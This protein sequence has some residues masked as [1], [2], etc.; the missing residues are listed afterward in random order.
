LLG[1][2]SRCITPAACATLSGGEQLPGHLPR[3][4]AATRSRGRE[5]LVQRLRVDQLHHDP[6]T[7]AVLGH[8]VDGNHG[9]VVEP[10]GGLGLA[11]RPLEGGGPLL[12]GEGVGDLHFLDRDVAVEQLIRARQTTP[13]APRPMRACRRY[14]PAITRPRVPPMGA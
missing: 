2:T 3:P 7:A 5:H 10:G 6:R 12:V 14:R 13:M 1:L 4:A 9:R 8:V 11:Q